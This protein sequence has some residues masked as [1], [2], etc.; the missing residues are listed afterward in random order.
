MP[1]AQRDTLGIGLRKERR[2]LPSIKIPLTHAALPRGT[3]GWTKGYPGQM[4]N[5]GNGL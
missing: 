2:A 3:F 5:A 4:Q 1:P